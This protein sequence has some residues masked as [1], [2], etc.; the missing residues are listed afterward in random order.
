M[1]CTATAIAIPDDLPVKRWESALR[2]LAPIRAGIAVVDRRPTRARGQALR[3]TYDAAQEATGYKLQTQDVRMGVAQV[4]ARDSPCGAFLARSP[5]A[6]LRFR[7]I[8]RKVWLDRAVEEVGRL[9]GLAR[10]LRGEDRA[11][12]TRVE[13]VPLADLTPH[14]SS[15]RRHPPD[16]I[17]AHPREHP[18]ARHVPQRR[19]HA[20]RHESSRG[21]AC[22]RPPARR[23]W[24]RSF[25]RCWTSRP[26]TRA[27]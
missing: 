1:A 5:S 10:A 2:Q 25:A 22:A 7:R 8:Q 11:P 24:R 18:R 6:S 21:T 26:T 3:D 27:R 15:P 12:A 4:P 9:C 14:P 20:Q 23:A 16:Q 13:M 19:R 17:R